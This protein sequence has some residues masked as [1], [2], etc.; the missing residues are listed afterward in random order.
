MNA[1]LMWV[2]LVLIV[3]AVVVFSIIRFGQ[4]GRGSI[5]GPGGV[6]AEF[7]GSNDPTPGARI[8]D[9]ESSEGGAL[10]E[11]ET[12]R[13]ATIERTKV[14]DDLIAANRAPRDTGDNAPKA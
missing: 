2:L 3:A 12:G 8:F 13:G 6:K 14:K 1:N 5:S 10:A 11:D 7:D 9:A 4:R